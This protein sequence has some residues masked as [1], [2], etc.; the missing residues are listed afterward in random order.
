MSV[1]RR[2]AALWYEQDS[3]L[4]TNMKVLE[5]GNNEI[6]RD[7]TGR[8][9]AQSF[10]QDCL[11]LLSPCQPSRFFGSLASV[12]EMIFLCINPSSHYFF[13]C[14][15]Q[16]KVKRSALKKCLCSDLRET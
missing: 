13:F 5:V 10:L 2:G 11:S 4:H 16:I 7:D 9:G 14:I 6:L 15:K 3:E 12:S 1:L 8:T